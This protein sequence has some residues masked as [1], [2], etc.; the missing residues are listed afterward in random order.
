MRSVTTSLLLLLSGLFSVVASAQPKST[1]VGGKLRF[2]ANKYSTNLDTGITKAEGNVK[3][4]IGPRT[5]E[6]DRVEYHPQDGSLTAEGNVLFKE[7]T[8]EVQGSLISINADSGFGKF[9]NAVMLYG[10]QFSVEADELSY[11]ANNRFRADYAKISSCVD[12]PQAW[13]VTGSLIDI[14]IEGFAKIHH[15]MVMIKDVPIAYFPVFYIPVKSKRQSGFLVPQMFF[16]SEL[17]SGIVFPYFWAIAPNADATFRY[18]YYQKAGNRAWAELRYMKSDRTHLNLI[19]SYNANLGIRPASVRHRYGY[20]LVQRA[21]IAPQWVQRFRSEFAS[22]PRYSYQFEKDFASSRQSTLPT[23]ASLVWQNDRY[24]AES[25]LNLSQDNIERGENAPTPPYGPINMLPQVAFA[26]PNVALGGGAFSDFKVESLSLRR[27]SLRSAAA[28][29]LDG[30]PELWI[31]TG[32]RLTAQASIYRPTTVSWISLNPELNLRFD[33]YRLAGDLALREGAE[34]PRVLATPQR[35]RWHF[36]Q[37]VET[38]VSRIFEVDV[39]DLRAVRHSIIPTLNWSYSPRDVRSR[40]PFFDDESAPR[41]DIFDP[42]SD[43]AQDGSTDVLAERMLKPHNLLFMGFR[44]QLTGRFGTDSRSYQE[45]LYLSALQAYDLENHEF[46]DFTIHLSAYRYGFTIKARAEIEWE[47]K[48]V[49]LR[50][51]ISYDTSFW[52]VSAAQVVRDVPPES[53][54]SELKEY[55]FGLNFKRLGPVE[56]SGWVSYD[57]ILGHDKEQNYQATYRSASKCWYFTLGVSRK[58]EVGSGALEYAPYIGV[59]FNEA[60][61]NYLPFN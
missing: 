28:S 8:L 20:S 21:Q 30:T 61:N 27:D 23:D 6:A 24:F 10:G 32:D 52:K 49:N 3:V 17:G 51:E 26:A 38:T 31:R 7:P 16:G 59:I 41:F 56:L 35:F 45:F 40:H 15:A 60:G 42:N 2:E 4:W 48:Q 29:G 9:K 34:Y 18:D 54:I 11:Y 46:E 13:S 5:V 55:Q 53:G 36:K 1:S 25:F 12:C 22:D 50:N 14:E 19:S 58:Q 39:G 47:I 44:T 37:D 33:Q 43:A 57:G